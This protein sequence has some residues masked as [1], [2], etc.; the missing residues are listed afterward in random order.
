VAVVGEIA[1]A[2]EAIEV[3]DSEED[4]LPWARHP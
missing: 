1:I 3:E 2:E 4:V